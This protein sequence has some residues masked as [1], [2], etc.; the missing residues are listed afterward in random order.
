MLRF[1]LTN[2]LLLCF[3]SNSQQNYLG[4]VHPNTFWKVFIS[5]LSI[6][7]HTTVLGTLRSD[8]GGVHENVPEK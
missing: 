2:P 3:K 4:C 6:R 7:V 5:L 1:F 8:S